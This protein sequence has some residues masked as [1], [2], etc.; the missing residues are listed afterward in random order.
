MFSISFL[1]KKNP[2]AEQSLIINSFS[3]TDD[4]GLSGTIII[5]SFIP[6]KIQTIRG[7]LFSNKTQALSP[8]LKPIFF[9]YF[10]FFKT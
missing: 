1:S 8:L 5:P 7:Q 6:A 3:I 2:F 9:K 10:D 4:F